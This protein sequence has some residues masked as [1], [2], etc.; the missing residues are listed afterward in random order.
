MIPC[1]GASI[2]GQSKPGRGW[3][4][5]FRLWA[6]SVAAQLFGSFCLL[7]AGPYRLEGGGAISSQKDVVGDEGKMWGRYFCSLRDRF[8]P[9]YG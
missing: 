4:T 3:L 7:D 9:D 2:N 1:G 8:V 6:P 5:Y